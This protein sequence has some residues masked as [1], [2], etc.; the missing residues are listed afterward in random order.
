M[1]D[2]DNFGTDRSFFRCQ[3]PN[4]DSAA[5]IFIRNQKIPVLLQDKS[6]DGFSVLVERRYTGK[7]RIGPQWVLQAGDERTEVLAQWM[8]NAPDG[9]VQIGLRRLQDLTPQPKSRLFPVGSGYRKNVANPELMFSAMFIIVI[10]GL[11]LPG[12]GDH[13]GTS[14]YIQGGLTALIEAVKDAG[15]EFW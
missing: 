4:E 13:L 8:F 6:I 14:G 2:L 5:T 11:S 1:S 3:V 10:L 7:L 12:L 9:H 15:K